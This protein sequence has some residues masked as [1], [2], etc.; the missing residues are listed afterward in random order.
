MSGNGYKVLG[1][2]VWKGT[3]WYLRNRYGLAKRVGAGV[4]AAGAMAAGAVVLAQRR[5][6]ASH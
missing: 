1:F 2:L 5:S 6:G 3:S 4:L